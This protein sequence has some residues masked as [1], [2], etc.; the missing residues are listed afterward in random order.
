[1]DVQ[2]R[3]KV[4]VRNLNFRG[5]TRRKPRHAMLLPTPPL[6]SLQ[7]LAQTFG[8]TLSGCPPG[9]REASSLALLA[10]SFFPA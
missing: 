7:E 6:G 4:C 9:Q 2:I 1:M 5:G 3:H 8:K 10:V